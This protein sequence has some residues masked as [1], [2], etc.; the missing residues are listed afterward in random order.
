MLKSL[1]PTFFLALLTAALA[2]PAYAQDTPTPLPQE[3]PWAMRPPT[4]QGA[5]TPTAAEIAAEKEAE[6]GTPAQQE[7]ARKVVDAMSSQ[8]F[9]GAQGAIRAVHAPVHRQ[10]PGLSDRPHEEAIRASDQQEIQAHDYQAAT[11]RD[12]PE[13]I[14]HLPDAADSS[15]GNGIYRRGRRY[16]H[17]QPDHGPGRRQM[18]RGAAVSD[19]SRD[20]A[21]RE[22]DADAAATSRKG[23][24]GDFASEDPVKSQLLAL[25]SKHDTVTA[26]RL[27]MRLAQDR[28]FNL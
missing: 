2:A 20:G 4:P 25:I 9:D 12:E 8:D 11:G 16:R 3:S 27:C 13:Q 23:G 1:R 21:V 19:R 17:G 28:L 7:L 10:E 5:G 15:D 26:W 18:V 14:F 6:K 22:A 24:G